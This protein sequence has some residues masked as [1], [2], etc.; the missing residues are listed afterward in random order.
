M[1]I[2]IVT[3]STSELSLALHPFYKLD[4]YPAAVQIDFLNKA[5]LCRYQMLRFALYDEDAAAGQL[6]T[7]PLPKSAPLISYWKAYRVLHET[8][9]FVKLYL[10]LSM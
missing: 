3:I 6:S 7:S 5:A 8:G 10:V 1:S 9:A 4:D 2:V